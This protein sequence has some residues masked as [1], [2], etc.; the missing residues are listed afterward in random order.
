MEEILYYTFNRKL[1]VYLVDW[2]I[3]E[4]ILEFEKEND[5]NIGI[6]TIIIERKEVNNVEGI[7][8][9]LDTQY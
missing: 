6:I 9:L 7:E 2:K 4:T 3:R 1:S 8:K 5:N